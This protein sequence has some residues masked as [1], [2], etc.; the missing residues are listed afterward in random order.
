[1]QVEQERI[2]GQYL[3]VD[4]DRL[5]EV[6]AKVSTREMACR[7]L[8]EHL[9]HKFPACEGCKNLELMES[10]DHARYR[11]QYAVT[12]KTKPRHM[13]AMMTCPDGFMG[14]FDEEKKKVIEVKRHEPS[15]TLAPNWDAIYG[16]AAKISHEDF[17]RE[18]MTTPAIAEENEDVMKR[19]VDEKIKAEAAKREEF[20][21]S[22]LLRDPVRLSGLSDG[23]AKI[24][25]GLAD[26]L[27]IPK[28]AIP[29]DGD[30]RP[31]RPVNKDIPLTNEEDA[32]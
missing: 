11:I 32:W 2:A 29:T 24:S 13:G 6:S 27:G 21:R 1:M 9:R 16:A 7:Q 26:M 20:L 5:L 3:A 15:V 25:A 8:G 31:A 14:I 10:Q 12:C 28:R 18:Y 17:L 30:L 22:S 4:I 19:I 23:E